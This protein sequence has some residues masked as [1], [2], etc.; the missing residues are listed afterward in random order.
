MR[1]RCYSKSCKS[2]KYYGARGIGICKRW[3][4]SFN[5]F[6]EDMGPRPS[7]EHSIDR[8]DNDGD[9]SPENCRWATAKQ[10]NNNKRKKGAAMIVE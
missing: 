9:Y 6:I 7:K 2:Y 4:Q 3:M 1:K 10:Q 8:I 5:H